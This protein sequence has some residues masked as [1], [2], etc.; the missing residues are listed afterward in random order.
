MKE[1]NEIITLLNKGYDL[2]L[3]QNEWFGPL[4]RITVK[5]I[6]RTDLIGIYKSVISQ[7]LMA[8]W[9]MYHHR[10]RT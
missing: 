2:V 4:K 5:G 6:N 9:G 8:R 3:S 1:I 7:S 10:Y